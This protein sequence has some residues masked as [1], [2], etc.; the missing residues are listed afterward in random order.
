ML[1]EDRRGV[2]RVRMPLV[3]AASGT[4]GP[5]ELALKVS[6]WQIGEM[7]KHLGFHRESELIAPHSLDVPFSD[8]SSSVTRLT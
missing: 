6:L 1:Q 2:L 4:D 8:P 5:H 3:S 7:L